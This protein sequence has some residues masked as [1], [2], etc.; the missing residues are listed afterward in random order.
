[1]RKRFLLNT[2]GDREASHGTLATAIWI[3]GPQL[4]PDVEEDALLTAEDHRDLT[5][6]HIARTSEL[7]ATIEILKWA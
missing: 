3:R 6:D 5:L 4:P 1:M 7:V 2:N